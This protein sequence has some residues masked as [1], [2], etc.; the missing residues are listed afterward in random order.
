M[1]RS[2]APR[3]GKACLALTT[4][5]FWDL[6]HAQFCLKFAPMGRSPCL[7]A[8]LT[9]EWVVNQPGRHGDLPLRTFLDPSP[10][11]H[12]GRDHFLPNSY[13]KCNPGRCH[14]ASEAPYG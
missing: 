8:L 13:I 2:R 4:G 12:L 6:F 14:M 11:E 7:S 10:S 5:I 1:A 3:H 9:P